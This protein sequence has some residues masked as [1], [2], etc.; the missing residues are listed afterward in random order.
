MVIDEPSYYGIKFLFSQTS[1]VMRRLLPILFLAALLPVAAFAD[2]KDRYIE[3]WAAT[4]VREMQRSG[5]P[6][7]ITLAQGL[8]ESRAG[9]SDLAKEGNNHF[10]IK[11]HSGWTGGRMYHDDDAKG[12]CFR[13]YDS[14]EESFRDHSDFLTGRQ[15]YAALFR[16][17]ITDYKGWAE[18]LRKAGY[19][20]SPSYASQLIK[21]I[22]DY[23]LY[24]YDVMS[25]A[26]F[27][28]EGQGRSAV[29]K[30]VSRKERKQAAKRAEEARKAAEK[31]SK[32][33]PEWAPDRSSRKAARRAR[34]AAKKGN[35]DSRYSNEIPVGSDGTAPFRGAEE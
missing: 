17:D 13:V 33:V 6:A 23:K 8:V 3:K 16:L 22:E 29:A 15:R 4:A 25:P 10:G 30:K 11:C 20:T 21:V 27:G 19:A 32:A 26:D 35:D 5:I 24:E 18:G 1:R 7:S 14:A 28:D 2:E 12:E 34:K 31:N 9:L